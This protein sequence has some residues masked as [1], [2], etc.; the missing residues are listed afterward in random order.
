MRRHERE[1]RRRSQIGTGQQLLGCLLI[2]LS[3]LQCIFQPSRKNKK[4]SERIQPLT[5]HKDAV[6]I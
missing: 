3:K 5:T 1:L 6:E 2:T 4:I